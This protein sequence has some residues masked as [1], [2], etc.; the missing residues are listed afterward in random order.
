MFSTVTLFRMFGIPVKAHWSLLVV[1]GLLASFAWSKD[2]LAGAVAVVLIGA[3]I[4]ASVL[5][6]EMG[7][8]LTARAYGAETRSVVLSP[9]GGVAFI[10]RSLGSPSVK[11]AVAAAGPAVSFALWAGFA[12]MEWLSSGQ[13]ALEAGFGFMAYVNFMLFAFNMLPAYPMDGGR[14][15]HALVESWKGTVSARD[16][17]VAVGTSIFAAMAAWGIWY[18]EVVLVLIAALM[19]FFCWAELDGPFFR[20]ATIRATAEDL[21]AAA[22]R[23]DGH[24]DGMFVAFDGD[25]RHFAY[26]RHWLS[27][28]ADEDEQRRIIAEYAYHARRLGG[29]IRYLTRDEYR[30]IVASSAA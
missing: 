19:C 22:S 7:H 8:V 18:G 12:A 21:F 2:G 13:E 26:A 1:L 14:L 30:A 17:S 4:A 20:R 25:G 10:E 3:A 6:H 29:R 15:L 16:V 9:L 11:A 27:C 23:S 24:L 28:P 5:A